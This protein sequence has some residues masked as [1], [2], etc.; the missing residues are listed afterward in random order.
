MSSQDIGFIIKIIS[1]KLKVHADAD[2][3]KRGLTISQARVLGFLEYHDGQATQKEIEQHLNVA[4]P[5]VVGLVQRLEK[6]G[7]LTCNV[8][9]RD[10]RNRIIMQ[11]KK[12]A[13][14]SMVLE[15]SLDDREAVLLSGLSDEEIDELRR[16]LYKIYHNIDE[17]HAG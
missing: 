8:D 11:T 5:T 16:I 2:L 10:K 17:H 4:H 1:E 9:P 15:K 3:K 6:N 7:F 12:A 13:D 14:M